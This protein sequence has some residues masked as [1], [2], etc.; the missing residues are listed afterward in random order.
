MVARWEQPGTDRKLDPCAR[1]ARTGDGTP[2][3]AL[4][5]DQRLLDL[6]DRLA[7][8]GGGRGRTSAAVAEPEG[9]GHEE[10]TDP[11]PQPDLTG[12]RRTHN[13]SCL[14]TCS[15]AASPYAPVQAA[16]T[17]GAQRPLPLGRC[18]HA[19]EP[20]RHRTYGANPLSIQVRKRWTLSAGHGP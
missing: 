1:A 11:P 18:A 7:D 14:L 12:C 19:D 13:R 4:G 6:G 16:G 8:L 17:H 10:G 2:E 9:R 3:H 20:S 5:V 15:F